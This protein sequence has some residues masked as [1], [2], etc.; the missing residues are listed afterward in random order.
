MRIRM[1][2]WIKGGNW[3]K[4]KQNENENPRGEDPDFW[5]KKQEES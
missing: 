3:K 4:E 2:T 5:F 1:T